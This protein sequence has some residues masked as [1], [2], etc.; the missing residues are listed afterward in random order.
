MM[1]DLLKQMTWEDIGEILQLRIDVEQEFHNRNY[2]EIESWATQSNPIEKEVLRRLRDKYDAIPNPSERFAEIKEAAERATGTRLGKS[3]ERWNMLVRCF[4]SRQMRREGYSLSEIGKAM[5]RDHAS[6]VN[7]TRKLEW[8]LS[9][10]KA[11][12]DEADKYERFLNELGG[13]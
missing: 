3:R 7:Q 2:S 10:P 11:Y 8:M 13:C 1:R 9:H 12:M 5:G 6:I 4:I